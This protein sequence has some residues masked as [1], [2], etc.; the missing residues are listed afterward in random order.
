MFF[1]ACCLKGLIEFIPKYV[2]PIM[3]LGSCVTCL[4]QA[5]RQWGVG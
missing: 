4:F 2:V 3:A 1:L 5:F